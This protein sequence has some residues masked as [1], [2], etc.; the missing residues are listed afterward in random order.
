[1]NTETELFKLFK[2][3]GMSDAGAAGMLAN[4]DFEARDQETVREID[5]G[6]MDKA[7]FVRESGAF[8]L[9]GWTGMH[10]KSELWK[11]WREYG[12]SIGDRQMQAEFAVTV[13]RE[14]YPAL[15]A[16][17]CESEDAEEA[18]TAVLLRF[19]PKSVG[20]CEKAKTRAV[21]ILRRMRRTNAESEQRKDGLRFAEDSA[22]HWPPEAVEHDV[23]D[24]CAATAQTIL[25]ARGYYDGPV[26]G[27]YDS[28]TQ[29]AVE[30]FQMAKG[31][32]MSRELDRETW[33]RLLSL[34]A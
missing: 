2:S 5:C 6:E 17:L 9:Y 23:L 20:Q 29:D 16:E 11:F 34:E 10:L 26:T 7:R 22:P 24:V 15:Y 27:V 32:R 28:R 21:E 4:A 14:S 18:A 12:G 13:L 33:R 8:G 25:L 19:T 31:L 1:M 30:A 3:A